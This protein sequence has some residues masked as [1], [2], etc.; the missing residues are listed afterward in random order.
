M[1]LGRDVARQLLIATGVG[2][3]I[4]GV[5]GG[6]GG[7]L[8]MFALRV[9]SPDS[10]IGVQTD[11]DFTVGRFSTSTFFL[12]G[13]TAGLGVATALLYLLVRETCPRRG[14]PL[15]IAAVAALYLGAD[16]IDP[17]KLDFEIFEPRSFAVASFI[18]MPAVAALAIGWVLERMLER[19]GRPPL[20]QIVPMA[21][22]AVPVLPLAPVIALVGAV[23]YTVRNQPKAAAWCLRVG[24]V[25]V[26]LGL[27]LLSLRSG[28]ELWRD[29][30]QTL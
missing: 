17:H 13:V 21:I 3:L 6:I 20:W 2:A 8:V 22:A 14:R 16:V 19:E 4:G 23:V 27:A 5:V 12:L 9:G 26:P 15:V 1:T 25:A 11:D 7:R 30:D 18:A 10:V 29:V 28:V 24:R